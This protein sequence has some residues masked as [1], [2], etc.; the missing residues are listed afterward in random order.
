MPYFKWMGIDIVGKS[1]KGRHIAFSS[2]DLSHKLL[3]QG[4]AL[5]NV[6]VV[7]TPKLLWPLNAKM[8]SDIFKQAA[9]LLQAGL[10]LPKALEVITQQSVHPFIHDALYVLQDDIQ[11]GIAFNKALEKHHILYD[12]IAIIMLTAGYESGNLVKALENMALYFHKQY[13][14][15]NNIRHILAI[16]LL[17]LLFFIGISFFI[18]VFII[19]RFADMF[20]SFQQELP[21]LTRLMVSC[22]EFLVSVSMLYSALALG[23]FI[24]C[25]YRYFNTSSGR[26]KWNSIF[27][28]LPFINNIVWSYYISQVLQACA[29]LVSTGVPFVDSLKIVTDSIENE[30]VQLQLKKVYNEVVA[31]QLLSN[32]MAST[33]LFLP[34]VIA[35]IC[36][37]EQ[38]GNLANALENAASIYNDAVEIHLKRFIF[39]LQP[40]LIILLGLLVTMLIFA[41][42]SPILQL[43]Y[44]V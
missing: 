32:V 30:A 36:V 11:K 2:E 16:P 20:S 15:N 37:G 6:K 17:T 19:P 24:F 9:K 44:V 34:E 14:F 27:S 35:L 21:A 1:K 7:R 5:L 40:T 29:L 43:S 8:K 12:P 25:A 22:S 33:A 31:G 39:I 13:V 4:V 18:F 42:Y 3:Q 38:T 26:K 23:A 41:V 28:H 10:L